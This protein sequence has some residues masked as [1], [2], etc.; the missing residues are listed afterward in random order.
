MKPRMRKA[1]RSKTRAARFLFPRLD[2]LRNHALSGRALLESELGDMVVIE[3]KREVEPIARTQ[4]I[5]IVG[6]VRI[7]T[8]QADQVIGV[9][10]LHAHARNR[11][12]GRRVVAAQLRQGHILEALGVRAVGGSGAESDRIWYWS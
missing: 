12:S 10:D 11:V 8:R 5:E 3:Q 9:V 1:T 2:R 6:C 7:G 4:E